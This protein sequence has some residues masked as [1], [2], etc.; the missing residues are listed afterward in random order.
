MPHP[1]PLLPMLALTLLVLVEE[2]A[3]NRDRL[4]LPFAALFAAA[5][6]IVIII[7]N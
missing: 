6:L 1:H 2:R 5:A 3:P 7:P 4:I